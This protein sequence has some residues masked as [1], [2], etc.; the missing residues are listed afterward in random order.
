MSGYVLVIASKIRVVLGFMN[1]RNDDDKV[2]TTFL[3]VDQCN[4]PDVTFFS[5]NFHPLETLLKYLLLLNLH[6][7]IF[8]C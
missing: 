1:F 5:V 4:I 2:A 6:C 3:S 8:S 7:M